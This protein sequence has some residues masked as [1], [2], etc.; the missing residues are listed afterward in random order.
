MP[1]TQRLVIIVLSQLSERKKKHSMRLA[2]LGNMENFEEK[3][4]FQYL[5]FRY[6]SSLMALKVLPPSLEANAG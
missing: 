3:N 5:L 6:I 4:I 1:S 2:E